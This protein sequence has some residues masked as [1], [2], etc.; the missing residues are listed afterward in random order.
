MDGAQQLIVFYHPLFKAGF[1]ARVSVVAYGLKNGCDR[2]EHALV[3][4]MVKYELPLSS[5]HM[6]VSSLS[7]E[8]ILCVQTT[9]SYRNIKMHLLIKSL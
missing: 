6:S 4:K 5:V 2:A 3:K 1:S 7:A 9:P 8:N